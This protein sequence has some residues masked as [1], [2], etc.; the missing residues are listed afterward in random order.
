MRDWA[1][2]LR[3]RLERLAL[4]P[5]REAEIMEEMAQHLDERYEELRRSGRSEEEAA[6]AALEELGEPPVLARHMTPL[7]QSQAPRPVAPG[8]PGG[9][10]LGDLW[11]D[12]RHSVR[13]VTKQS[14]FASAVV[15]TLGLGIG[16]TTAMFTV[17]HGVLLKPLAFPE[18]ERIIALFHDGMLA[19]Q[20]TVMNHG[21]ATY[22]TYRENQRTFEDIGAWERTDVAITGAGDPE[23]VSALAVTD[24]T[25]PVL[26][27]T[28][29]LGR[30]FR[31][32]EDLP[33]SPVTLVLTHGYW[34]RRFGGA[35][36]VVGRSIS[37]DGESATIIGVLPPSFRFPRAP[38]D[39][40]LPLQPDRAEAD[41]GISFGFQV[42]GRLRPGV[43]L[44]EASADV[45]RM[46]PILEERTPGAA[47]FELKPN[48]YP[49]LGYA[50]ADVGGTL[51][52]L[53]GT[54]GVVLIIACANVANL[55]LI[56]A[57]G[58]HRELAVRT[59]L[60]AGRG[61]LSRALLTESLVLG[62]AGGA[63]GIAFAAAATALLRRI[64]PAELPRVEDIGLDPQVL[65]F[66]LLVSLVASILFGLIPVSRLGAPSSA[67]L[68]EGGRGASEGPSRL[69]VRNVLAVTEVAMAFVL[70]IVSGL[71]VR[72]ALAMQ[73][74]APGFTQPENVQTLR[75]D[76]PEAVQSDP[77]EMIRVHQQIG[78]R[79]AAIPGIQSVGIASSVTMDGEDN[80]NPFL[81]ESE[82]PCQDDCYRFRRFKAV[83]PGQ[84]ATAGNP[85]VAGRDLTWE[86]IY[87]VRPV[88]L[89]SDA[90]A[91][92]VWGSAAEAIGQRI[93]PFGSFAAWHEVVGVVGDER[94]D[95]LDRP[96]TGILYWPLLNDALDDFP[97]G[98]GYIQSMLVYSLRSDRVGE[99]GL[100]RELRE[101]VW[102]VNPELPI[103]DMRTLDE[104][105]AQSMAS[106]S[107]AMVMLTIAAAIALLLA[108][109][110][111]YGVI[112]YVA[113]Q[114][115][116]EVGIRLA[117]GAEVGN[118]RAMFLRYGLGLTGAGIVL[119]IAGAVLLTR[120]LSALLYGVGPTDRVTYA[121]VSV[122]L[123]AAT[124]LATSLP[125][126]RAARVDPV[127]AMR[128]DA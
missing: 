86:D 39:V 95:G 31:A 78:E 89:V 97:N 20:P 119:G 27:V 35:E 40:V 28:P 96:P 57:E 69:R 70:L 22:F 33:G 100:G 101:A 43:T 110:G 106:T 23:R 13:T 41:G 83:G 102:S 54:A 44:A 120:I 3:P 111:V 60:G 126:R 98:F 123:V 55:F 112:A 48:L 64:A 17:V 63:L 79:L 115:T 46:I 61:R 18:P 52:I 29:L 14:A 25:L 73:Q 9:S 105:R 104:I 93:K 118:V 37:V 4:S 103:S 58:R 8:A 65:L 24:G 50:A 75:V 113:V 59:V 19:S 38:A 90:L 30:F 16:T 67:A 128:A 12:V 107:F 11:Q 6:R 91:K 121:A 108:M 62:L 109:I 116:R 36:D 68:R 127:I 49:L 7:R 76:V 85:L 21:P 82:Q 51:W 47:S 77:R 5:A 74:V 80:M 88:L 45:E 92:E 32:E 124:L 99:P 15:L 71:M 122:V 34:L 56:R 125:V 66:T 1:E 53:L 117:L 42:I 94:D 2:H 87:E 10:L 72:T 81:T 26:G 114:R 84:F